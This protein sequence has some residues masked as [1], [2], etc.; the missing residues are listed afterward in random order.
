MLENYT[1]T[2]KFL[3]LVLRHKPQQIGIELMKGGWAPV[4]KVLKGLN[5]SMEDLKYIVDTDE[6]K[7]YSFNE[8]KTLIR[9]NQGHSINIDMQFEEQKP[10]KYLYHGTAT[11]FADGIFGKGITKQNRQYV[12]LSKDTETAV[13]VGRRHGEPLVL[14]VRAEEMY[15]NGYKFY[16]SEN[17]VWLT[18]I[19]PPTYISR[20]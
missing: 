4:D 9:A 1:K 17:G 15:D 10:P 2:S 8:D 16:L 11:K 7:R 19:V 20:L 14:L 5:I 12:H 13:K 6:K 3:S 18:D